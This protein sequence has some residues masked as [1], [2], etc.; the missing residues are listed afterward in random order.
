M[1]V[2]LSRL[3]KGLLIEFGGPGS[4]RHKEIIPNPTE[5]DLA[6]MLKASPSG[7]LR[8]LFGKKDAYVADAHYQTHDEMMDKIP[9]ERE[10]WDA[11]K[12]STGVLTRGTAGRRTNGELRVTASNV[13]S[14]INHPWLKQL[15]FTP[16]RPSTSPSQP[17][18]VFTKH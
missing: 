8:V 18:Q 14:V 11:D 5:K 7:R 16:E 6:K 9:E 12:S 13:P 17:L 15:N 10:Y 3:G 1:L 2:Q 4:G